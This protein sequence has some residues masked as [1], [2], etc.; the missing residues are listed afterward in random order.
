MDKSIITIKQAHS[1]ENVISKSR[2]IAYIKPVSTEN[3]AKAFIDEIKTKHKD[4]THNC[5]AYTVGPEMNIQKANDDGEPSGT[6]GIPMLEI[7]KK[8]EIHNVCVVVTRYF[9]GIKLGAGGLIRAYSGAVRDVIYDIGRVELREAITVTVTLDYDQTGK[10]EYE[11]AST[12]FLLR[13]QF[14]T[15]KVS[16]QID[17]VKN[18]YDAFIDF[19]NR[20][21]SGN[22]DLK[23]EDLKLLPFEIETN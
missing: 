23:Q 8:L 7:L 2:F 21:T 11:L 14:Y 5:S 19:L 10:F 17:V 9:G 1:I 6:A 18:E 20:I 22:Y 12:T 3:E 15:D 16:Y 13:E 4:A